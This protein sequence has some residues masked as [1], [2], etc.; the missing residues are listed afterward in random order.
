MLVPRRLAQ[1]LIALLMIGTASAACRRQDQPATSAPPPA[2]APQPQPP[3][4]AADAPYCDFDLSGDKADHV[5][6]LLGMRNELTGVVFQ[7]GSDLLEDFFCNERDVA[8]TYQRV[9][10]T[11]QREQ[12]LEADLRDETIQSC[13]T[14]Y[15][16]RSLARRVRSCFKPEDLGYGKSLNVALFRR[17]GGGPAWLT[18]RGLTDDSFYRRRA[19]A[20]LSGA[21]TRFHH[22]KDFEFYGG[23]GKAELVARLLDNLGCSRITIESTVGVAPGMTRVHF[24]PTDEVSAWLRKE[25]Q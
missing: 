8:R 13:R 1:S 12:G 15:Y 9:A 22:A 18:E 24:E 5:F 4:P 19:L 17:E 20:Y 7:D 23:R 3:R 16:S 10:A 25:W 6:F 2:L 21:W 11:M 14:R